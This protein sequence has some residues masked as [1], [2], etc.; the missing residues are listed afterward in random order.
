MEKEK[1]TYSKARFCYD[2][3]DYIKLNEL[4]DIDWNTTLNQNKENINGQWE[5]FKAI[6]QDAVKQCIPTKKTRA[7]KYQHPVPLDIQTRT[8][9]K[10]KCRLW[11]DYMAARNPATYRAY[12]TLRNQVRRL[13]RKA[14]NCMR[15]I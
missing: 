8:K 4:L 1:T 3:G 13:T 2:K 14:T 7:G 9:M 6:Y 12:C 5:Q 10:R 15:G 11:K